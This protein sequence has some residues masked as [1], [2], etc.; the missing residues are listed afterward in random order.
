MN[1]EPRVAFVALGSNLDEPRRQVERAL[2]RL[3]RLP[4]TRVTGTSR[5]YRSEP[6]GVADQPDFVNAVVRLETGLT[7]RALLDALLAVERAHGRTRSAE[8]W[9]PRTLDLDLLLYAD[10]VLDE[11]GLEVP[12]PGLTA[13]AFVLYPLAELAPDL[14]IP[15]AGPLRDWLARVPADGLTVLED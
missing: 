12:H 13:R 14:G 9:G 2:E 5:L 10:A 3:A 6:L 8:R 11:P 4:A 15:G 7:A 1:D